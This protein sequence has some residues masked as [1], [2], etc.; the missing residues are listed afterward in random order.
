VTP[1][2]QLLIYFLILLAILLGGYLFKRYGLEF[3]QGRTQ[4][5]RKLKIEETRML[6]N[7][8]F[9]VVASYEHTRV[10]LGV[11]PGRIDYLCRLE[12]GLGPDVEESSSDEGKGN[13]FSS[14]LPET[15]Q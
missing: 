5:A 1:T 14:L 13:E 11:S 4:A 9:L 2:V 12:P 15:P 10:L 8:Q 3:L 7:R 6:G